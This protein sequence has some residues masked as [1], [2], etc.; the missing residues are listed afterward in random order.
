MERLEEIK[1]KDAIL[2]YFFCYHNKEKANV[3]GA[4]LVTKESSGGT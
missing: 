1:K 3:D 2:V 4:T